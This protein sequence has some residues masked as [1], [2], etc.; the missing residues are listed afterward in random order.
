MTLSLSGLIDLLTSLPSLSEAIEVLDAAIAF[1]EVVAKKT[2]TT[3]DDETLATV[4]AIRERLR[5]IFGSN[6]D[7]APSTFDSLPQ[8]RQAVAEAY[9]D[10]I[11]Q[12]VGS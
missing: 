10:E 5:P 7:G 6:G 2:K 3:V 8:A 9:A 11:R 12:A 1:G 4:K